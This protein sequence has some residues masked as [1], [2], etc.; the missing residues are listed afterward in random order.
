MVIKEH[1]QPTSSIRELHGRPQRK[2]TE[3]ILI[4][5][6]YI[7]AIIFPGLLLNNNRVKGNIYFPIDRA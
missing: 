5:I 7:N 2:G 1:T 6:I 4:T 3:Q